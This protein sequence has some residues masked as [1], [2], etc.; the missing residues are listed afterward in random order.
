MTHESKIEYILDKLSLLPIPHV[1]TRMVGKC[2]PQGSV[3]RLMAL[4]Y[5]LGQ[6]DLLNH[7][8]LAPTYTTAILEIDIKEILKLMNYELPENQNCGDQP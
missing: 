8:E 2:T 5:F 6:L 3:N 1:Y 7:P 4:S